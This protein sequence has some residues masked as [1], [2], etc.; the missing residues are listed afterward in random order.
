M[1]KVKCRYDNFSRLLIISNLISIAFEKFNF[2][3]F[4]PERKTAHGEFVILSRLGVRNR[5]GEWGRADITRFRRLCLTW[6]HVLLRIRVRIVHVRGTLLVQIL[7]RPVVSVFEHLKRNAKQN[8]MKTEY[9]HFQRPR[10]HRLSNFSYRPVSWRGNE[11]KKKWRP[12][13]SWCI[14][15]I[16]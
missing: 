8:G 7:R 1:L 14:Y 5:A 16:L 11:N 9:K 6:R 3:Q 4:L 12:D 10:L 2:A 13:L 15:T